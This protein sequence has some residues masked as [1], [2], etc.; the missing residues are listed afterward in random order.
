MADS[1]IYVSATQ[2]GGRHNQHE[3]L[4]AAASTSYPK[5]T[6]V[7]RDASGRAARPANGLVIHG[8]SE[9]DFDNTAGANDAFQVQLALGV[10]RIAYTGTQPKKHDIV[11]AVDNQTVSLS[12]NSNVRGVAGSVVKVETGFVWVLIDP[13]INGLLQR[14]LAAIYVLENPGTEGQGL[15]IV[16]GVP[17]WTTDT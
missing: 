2:Y 12:S 4:N 11:F 17:A 3:T 10:H 16:S 13:V 9:G 15:K 6:M 1:E 5:G 7:A 14:L 8:V